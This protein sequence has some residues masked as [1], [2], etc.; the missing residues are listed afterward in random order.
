MLFAQSRNRS[1]NIKFPYLGN[2][3]GNETLNTFAEKRDS[4]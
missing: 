4:L 1:K 2:D 3:L